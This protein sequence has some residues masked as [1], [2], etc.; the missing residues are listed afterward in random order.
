M[1]YVIAVSGRGVS[2][3]SMLWRDDIDGS[4]L[5][6]GEHPTCD[7]RLSGAGIATCDLWC[8]ADGWR[9]RRPDGSVAKPSD[10]DSFLVGPWTVV[11]LLGDGDGAPVTGDIG[12][13]TWQSPAPDSCG[14]GGGPGFEIDGRRLADAGHGLPVLLGGGEGCAVR[15]PWTREAF[16]AIVRRRRGGTRCYPLAGTSLMRNG[17]PIDGPETLADG[18]VLSL[19]D[20][21]AI[22]FV[23][24]DEEIDRLLGILRGES[25]SR[26]SDEGSD[27]RTFT[28]P[29]AA[30]IGGGQDAVFS[31]WEALLAGGAVAAVLAQGAISIARW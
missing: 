7:L 14:G 22:R 4:L 1:I 20:A 9:V 6:I 26:P 8:E 10:G 2:K 17:R 25:A 18:D 27:A 15:I 5:R 11:L 29:S 24:P 21:P 16:A 3:V 13:S 28:R 19:A 23:D 31:I 12:G 30:V